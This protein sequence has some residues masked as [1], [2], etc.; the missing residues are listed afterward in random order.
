MTFSWKSTIQAFFFFLEKD[1]WLVV[2]H[3]V[4]SSDLHA[5]ETRSVL[6]HRNRNIVGNGLKGPAVLVSSRM[7]FAEEL[8]RH[9]ESLSHPFSFMSLASY[10]PTMLQ[11]PQLYLPDTSHRHRGLLLSPHSNPFPTLNKPHQSHSQPP[12]RLLGDI[13]WVDW[14]HPGIAKTEC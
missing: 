13:D 9:S 1:V 6:R 5:E 11:C 2:S 14:L 3:R 12:P 8:H 10:S 4:K 7:T